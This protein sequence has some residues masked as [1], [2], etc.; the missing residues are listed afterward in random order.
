M[1]ILGIETS[2][3]ETA[4]S[5][6]TGEGKILSNIIRSQ[7]D[8]HMAYG[9]V[10]PELASRAHIE[11]LDAVINAALKKAETRLTDI[12]AIAVTA[13][14]G[15][16]GGVIVGVME[17]KAIAAALG[18]P[19]IAVNH[20][21]AHALTARLS[22]DLPFPYLL[23][24]VSGGHTQVLLVKGVGNYE[25]MGET[26]DDAVGESFDKLAKS[27]GLGIPGGPKIEE[28]AL[29]GNK[30]AFELPRPLLGQKGCDFSL[31]GLKTAVKRKVDTN[32]YSPEDIC[33]VFQKVISDVIEDRMQNAISA[34]SV[35]CKNLVVAGGV[36]SNKAIRKKLEEVAAKNNMQLVAPP[37]NLCTDN[38]AMVAWAGIEKLKLG[39]VDDLNF[40]PVPRWPLA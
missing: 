1:K 32:E 18:K 36:A 16:I 27:L 29:R 26:L 40:K 6:V 7:F 19:F 4:A 13:G 9:G 3:D 24:L 2:C 38:A 34:L 30:N 28:L 37:I 33:A 39:Q 11:H 22:N 15:L 20:L 35:P 10:V 12:D 21:E 31:S 17:A 14:P 25:L 23:L 5:V 8:E